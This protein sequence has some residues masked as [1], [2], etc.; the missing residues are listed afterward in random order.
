MLI[1]YIYKKRAVTCRDTHCF[2][3]EGVFTYMHEINFTSLV[4]CIFLYKVW[5][6]LSWLFHGRFCRNWTYWR[7]K[8]ESKVICLLQEQEEQYHFCIPTLHPNIHESEVR[9]LCLD[10]WFRNVLN[11]VNEILE[12]DRIIFSTDSSLCVVLLLC[13]LCEM[14]MAFLL[15]SYWKSVICRGKY[16]SKCCLKIYILNF[17]CIESVLWGRWI[18]TSSLH[19]RINVWNFPHTDRVFMLSL[20]NLAFSC[21]SKQLGL[22]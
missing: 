21:L 3:R 19:F 16:R 22:F 10:S 5:D 12:N 9:C 6:S 2:H 20:Y 13:S 8:E 15:N 4:Y 14:Y 11:F 17:I 1:L 7:I 18:R